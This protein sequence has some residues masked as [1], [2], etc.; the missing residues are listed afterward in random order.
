L[1]V[2]IGLIVRAYDADHAFF[3]FQ[4]FPETSEWTA[5][6]VRID[7]A[8]VAHDIREPWTGGY[9]WEEMVD[10][11]GLD[12]PWALRPADAGMRSTLG[13]LDASLDWVA[14]HTPDDHETVRLEA[15]V[16]YWR[17]GRGPIT[18]TLVS[19]ER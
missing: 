1:I 6:I 14:T 18:T 11:R 8:G 5:R 2:Q 13:F 16:T 7:G 17:N 15:H 4:M 3:G 12:S 9:S 19:V 10:S